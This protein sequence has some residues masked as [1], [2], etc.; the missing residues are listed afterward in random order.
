MASKSPAETRLE[1]IAQPTD[2]AGWRQVRRP[3]RPAW[4]RRGDV[5]FDVKPLGLAEML[6][7]GNAISRTLPKAVL[8]TAA[9]KADESRLPAV[10]TPYSPLG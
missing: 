7:F 9:A 10:M 1:V 2:T 5:A 4:V 8:I 3:N 6:A